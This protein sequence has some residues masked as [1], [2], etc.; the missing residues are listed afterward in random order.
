MVLW[1]TFRMSDMVKVSPSLNNKNLFIFNFTTI[2][3]L[4]DIRAAGIFYC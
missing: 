2:E 3:P 4:L 1:C